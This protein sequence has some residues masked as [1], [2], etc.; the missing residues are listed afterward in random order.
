MK[1]L[2]DFVNDYE[3]KARPNN[4]TRLETCVG[5][6]TLCVYI[7]GEFK[8]SLEARKYMCEQAHAYINQYITMVESELTYEDILRTTSL[9]LKDKLVTA[10]GKYELRNS[11]SVKEYFIYLL[12]MYEYHNTN[13]ILFV[14]WLGEMEPISIDNNGSI[15]HVQMAAFAA[16]HAFVDYAIM[17]AENMMD[18][19][20][21]TY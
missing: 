13:P 16:I 17:C 15:R 2:K 21:K 20:I 10:I 6:S 4:G 18:K 14:E 19:E 1:N 11:L 5:M 9:V 7:L 8:E 12:H 3:F